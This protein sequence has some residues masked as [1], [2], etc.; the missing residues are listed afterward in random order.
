MTSA[1]V[2]GTGSWGTAYASV[3]ADAG[4]SVT[5]WG[6]RQEV[7]DQIN[8][9][10][11]E[12][13][14]PELR[15]PS[16]IRA[17]T[18]PFEAAAGADIVVLAV[19][20]QTLRANLEVWG[21]A[22]PSSAAIV[23]LMK[24]VELGTTRRMSEVISEVGG[25]EPERVVIV[26][27]PNLARE[28]AVKQPAA[29]V[30]ASSSPA[31]AE[32]VAAACAAPYFRPYTGSDVVGTEICGAVKNVIALAVGMAEGMGMG[33]NSKA[34]IITRGLAET[35]RLG[36][37]LGGEAPTFAG[38]AGVGDLIATCM[39][40]LSRNHS[41]GVRL[42]QGLAVSEVIAVTKQTA[43]GVKSC[44]SI[45]ELARHTGVDVPII[46]QVDAMIQHD[47]SAQEVVSALLSRPRKAET[48]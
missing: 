3:L 34:S 14:L 4:T 10:T 25:V 6:R 18:D 7:V 24:G 32:L 47:R 22:L 38:L 20:S 1:A 33:D 26:S 39:S 48:A 23:S 19:P 42:G 45:L 29:S 2:Y 8:A 31:M 21:S 13:Y 44:T 46:E 36:M 41:F 28:I 5:M 30:V 11:N 9:G 16:T 17:T 43:E 40:P 12:D 15:L 37:A 35:M 27:G